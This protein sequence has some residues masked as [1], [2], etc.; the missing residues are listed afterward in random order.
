MLQLLQNIK[1]NIFI[2]THY[3]PKKCHRTGGLGFHWHN[4]YQLVYVRRG[5]GILIIGDTTYSLS[6]TDAILIRP[7]E[8]HAFDTSERMETYEVKFVFSGGSEDSLLWGPRYFCR[9]TAGGIRQA[10]QQMEAESERADPFSRSLV[11]LSFARILLLMHRELAETG[12]VSRESPQQSADVLLEKINSYIDRNLERRF[13]VKDMATHFYTEYT[14]F[15]RV[16]SANYGVRL[17]QYINRRRIDRARELLTSTSLPVAEIAVKC[18][19][20]NL[21]N[22]ERNFKRAEGISPTQ[23]RQYYQNVFVTTFEECP[24]FHHYKTP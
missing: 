11:T 13:T 18:G 8:P 23:F 22:L 9:D 24:E 6:N 17:Q 5:S 14:H 21:S 4:Y 1:V 15:S 7:N 10:L 3:T 12:T 16:F 2:R 19:F 20:E